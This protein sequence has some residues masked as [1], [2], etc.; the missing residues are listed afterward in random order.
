MAIGKLSHLLFLC[1][2]SCKNHRSQTGNTQHKI[3]LLTTVTNLAEIGG[4]EEQELDA[5]ETRTT[6]VSHMDFKHNRHNKQCE[7][8]ISFS[9]MYFTAPFLSF[10][11]LH[12]RFINCLQSDGNMMSFTE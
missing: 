10:A 5:S 6:Q 4:L 3:T 1:S 7:R 11:G 9:E 12:Q 8:G 2:E